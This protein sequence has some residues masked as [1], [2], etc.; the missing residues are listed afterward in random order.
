MKKNKQ[1]AIIKKIENIRK[2]NNVLWMEILRIAVTTSP[3]KSKK[4]LKK[5]TI[6]DKKISSLVSRI[7]D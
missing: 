5:I 2:Q 3:E 7:Y 6:N 4:V 1:L